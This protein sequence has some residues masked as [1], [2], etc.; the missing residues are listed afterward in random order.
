M[1]AQEAPVTD[2]TQSPNI[3]RWQSAYNLASR[4]GYAHRAN[5]IQQKFKRKGWS[6]DPAQGTDFNAQNFDVNA[7]QGFRGMLSR[8]KPNGPI[9][10]GAFTTKINTALQQNTAKAGQD[11]FAKNYEP[12]VNAAQG[13]VQSF[14]EKPAWSATDVANRQAQIASSIKGALESR[15]RTQTSALGMRGL[16]PSSPAGA[17]VL[18][19]MQQSA[20]AD[21]ADSFSAFGLNVDA[22]NQSHQLAAA[23]ALQGIATSRQAAFAAINDPSKLQEIND[24]LGGLFEALRVQH[25][26]EEAA[27]ASARDAGQRDWLGMGLNLAGQA[28]QTAAGAGAFGGAGLQ[29]YRMGPNGYPVNASQATRIA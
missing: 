10:P 9:R 12:A 21:L 15:M 6:F 1:S 29:G 22:M 24:Q 17:A 19:R 18:A 26:A 25:D 11:Y 5:Q 28:V 14:A 20:D 8:G 7:A 2:P 13:V 4:L 27:K 23:Q 3:G 16:S